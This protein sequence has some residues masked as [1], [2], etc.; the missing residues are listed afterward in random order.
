MKILCFLEWALSREWEPFPEDALTSQAKM[1]LIK[2]PPHVSASLPLPHFLKLVRI[3]SYYRHAL[4]KCRKL[5]R[6]N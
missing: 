4:G 2:R 6:H 1:L 3:Q 5:P